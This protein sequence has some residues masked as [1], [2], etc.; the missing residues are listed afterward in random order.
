VTRAEL[1]AALEAEHRIANF[2][3]A[4]FTFASMTGR[5]DRLMHAETIP[6]D[7]LAVDSCRCVGLSTHQVVAQLIS[8]WW[9]DGDIIQYGIP[10]REVFAFADWPPE[11]KAIIIN[12]RRMASGS[13]PQSIPPQLGYEMKQRFDELKRQRSR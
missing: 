4:G 1:E 8:R 9:F 10:D 3:A 11:E 6:R 5:A 2:H 7:C 12:A 13:F